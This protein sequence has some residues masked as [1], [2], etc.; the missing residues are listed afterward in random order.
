MKNQINALEI[1]G[2]N[3]KYKGFSLCDVE[4]CIPKGSIVGLVGENGAG[5]STTMKAALNL[6]KRDAG[7]VRFW[8][9]N[10]DEHPRELK[11]RIGVSF[12]EINFYEVLT[13]LK[14]EKICAAVYDNW[15]KTEF[16]RLLKKFNVNETKPI[17]DFSRG[18]KVKLSLAVAMSHDAELLILD[19]PTSGL[20]PI[21]REDVL[22]EF[23]TFVKNGERSILL[24]SH[25][26]DDLEKIADSV[27]FIHKGK[28]VFDKSVTELKAQGR[29]IDDILNDYVRRDAK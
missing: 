3:K 5:K 11:H 22:E 23:E 28:I 9:E 10:L 8:G 2:L 15:D 24:S 17:I 7:E 13:P 16:E 21:A 18:M 27:V 20:D 12:D 6:V 29:P 25:I 4:I 14:V 19:E 26:T 1:K